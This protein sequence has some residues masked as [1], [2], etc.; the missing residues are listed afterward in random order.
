MNLAEESHKLNKPLKVCSRVTFASTSMPTLK[1][2]IV[3]LVM[4]EV[5]ADVDTNANIT[6]E[7]NVGR[8]LRPIYKYFFDV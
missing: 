1:L 7:R 8:L 3:S 5:D 4:Q 6:C 2:N